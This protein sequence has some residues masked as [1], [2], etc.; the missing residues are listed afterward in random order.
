[1]TQHK[2]PIIVTSTSGDPLFQQNILSG[3]ALFF[4]ERPFSG[5][6]F[7]KYIHDALRVQKDITRVVRTIE[8]R[9]EHHQAGIAILSY[10]SRV[11]E[12]KFPK[13]HYIVSITQEGSVVTLEVRTK[14]GM[15]EKVETALRDFGLVVKG[16]KP[17]EYLFDDK[18]EA[19]SL[20]NKLDIAAMELR[21]MEQLYNLTTNQNSNRIQKLD[22]E[23]GYL[24]QLVGDTMGGK[25]KSQSEF[26]NLIKVL[27]RSSTAQTASA[28]SLLSER[29]KRGL[30][31]E[32]EGDV[33]A[34]LAAVEVERP[35]FLER[36]NDIFIK[37]AISGVSS[38]YLYSWLVALSSGLP[39]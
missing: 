15:I 10:F 3:G 5:E 9:A 13:D 30:R 28:L 20:R 8:F 37:G 24:R 32:D 31:S 25:E 33:K 38:N 17:P 34:A 4:L 7:Q 26:L 6:V 18:L 16:E 36:L 2:I 1:L 21:H 29:Y 27:S 12:Q 22:E 35:G 19:M 14:D 11:L 39:K 23:V